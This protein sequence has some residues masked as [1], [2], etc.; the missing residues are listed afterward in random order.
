MKYSGLQKHLI[1]KLNALKNAG[2]YSKEHILIS[3]QSTKVNT[4]KQQNLINLSSSNYLGFS[5]DQR[6]VEYASALIDKYG[7]GLS[8][9]RFICGTTQHHL[10][11]EKAVASFYEKEDAI[12][13]CNGYSANM[14]LFEAFFSKE[15]AI[16][17]GN[18]SH[19]SLNEAANLTRAQRYY[20]PLFEIAELEKQL[21]KA[22]E[23]GARFKIIAFDGLIAGSGEIAPISKICDLADKYDALVFSDECHSFGIMGHKGRGAVEVE[24]CLNRVDVISGTFSKAMPGCNGGFLTGNKDIIEMLRQKARPYLFSN[25]IPQFTAGTYTYALKLFQNEP[26]H[27]EKLLANVHFTRKRLKE[28]KLDFT[29]HPDSPIIHI[30]VGDEKRAQEISDNLVYNEGVFAIPCI[31]PYTEKGKATIR[32]QISAQHTEEELAQS[33]DKVADA[34]KMWT[35]PV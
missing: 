9:V 19:E 32:L 27:R 18:R 16:I 29:G 12:L 15:D 35:I 2:L 11:L 23:N 34:V 20:F 8:S 26:E 4:D 28:A 31:Y 7:V 25:T 5:N 21:Q 3:P 33:I 10:E 6:L 17:I 24:N 13:F 22:N 1:S 14:A 30:V